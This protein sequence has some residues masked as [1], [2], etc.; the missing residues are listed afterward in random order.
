MSFR[1]SIEI[2]WYVVLFAPSVLPV[3][4]RIDMTEYMEN[5]GSKE[6]RV[7]FDAPISSDFAQ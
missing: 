2:F 6:T 1:T 3:V 7:P 5:E 4:Q